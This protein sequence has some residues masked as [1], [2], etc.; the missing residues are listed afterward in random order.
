MPQL[1][2][3]VEDSVRPGMPPSKSHILIANLYHYTDTPGG[4]GRLG[5]DET[6][7]LIANGHRVTVV[8]AAGDKEKLE[9]EREGNLCL[10]R[11]KVPTLNAADPRRAFAHQS[12]ARAVLRRHVAEPVDFVHGHVPLSYLA[13][14]EVFGREARTMYT[15]HSP[16]TME[17]DIE[18]PSE[19]LRQNIRRWFGLPLLK[20][21]ERRCLGQSA[22]VVSHSNFTR[23]EMIRIHGAKLGERIQVIPAWVDLNRF[24]IL[25]DREA[26]KHALG[27]SHDVPVLF[28]L[29]RLVRRM[30]LDRLVRAA[31]ILRDRGWRFQLIIGGAGPLRQE[32][33]QLVQ[34]LNLADCIRFV[35]RVPDADLPAM[36]GAC[37]AFV[38][39]TAGLECFGLIALEAL[40]CG[41]PVLATPIA[42]IPEVISNFESQWLARSA[43]E[44]AI[45]DLIGNYLSGNLPAHLPEELRRRTEQLYRKEELL[46]QLSN[47]LFER[48]SSDGN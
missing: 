26:A 12:A 39:P 9:V 13:A 30:G 32:L 1:T 24:K 20:H 43:G 7:H 17:M 46:P 4:A 45:A 10:L 14:C 48:F 6:Q 21:L 37:D 11:Y 38:L 40:A 3:D 35:G 33:E 16:S 29:R 23:R 34:T 41:R 36:Y 44:R 31:A 28:T 19:S 25:R 42:A 22:V 27:W 18:W 8:A 15:I 5:W 47:L 2:R